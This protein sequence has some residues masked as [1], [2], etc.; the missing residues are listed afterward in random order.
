MILT[1]E[2][3]KAAVLAKGYKWFADRPNIVMIRTE[4]DVPDSFNDWCTITYPDG[5]GETFKA[6]QNTTDPGLYWLEHPMNTLGTAVL[7]P[8]QYI[9]SH[10]IGFHQ[11]KPDHEAL[12]QVGKLTV[13]RNPDRTGKRD[14]KKWTTETGLFGINI[15]GSGKN[16]PSTVIGKWS[17]GCQVF[18]KWADKEEFVAICK[19]FKLL[20]K[21]RFTLTLINE[22]DLK[23]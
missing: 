16:A 13:Y 17:A 2:S 12:V 6:F 11:G 8:G 4:L 19:K 1:K 21:N 15:H 22:K 18:S 7:A 20:T 10:Q 23:A 5:S 3:V 9:D 14:S